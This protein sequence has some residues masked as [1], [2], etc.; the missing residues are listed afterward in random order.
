MKTRS[1]SLVVVGLC[2]FI[3]STSSAML[4]LPS[5]SVTSENKLWN[6]KPV[7]PQP[8]SLSLRYKPT[9]YSPS[10]SPNFSIPKHLSL[11]D[12]ILLALRNNPDV[13]AADL[14]RVTD[15]FALLIEFNKFQPQ[16]TF[17]ATTTYNARGVQ[18]Y[19]V[20]PTVK[21]KNTI[22]TEFDVDYKN[23]LNGSAGGATFTIKQSLLKGF[24]Y[25]NKIPFDNALDQEKVNKLAYKSSVIT[26]VGNVI[27][28][29]RA[30]MNDFASLEIQIHTLKT[31]EETA[32]Q[33]ALKVK[34]GKIAPSELI[35]QEVTVSTTRQQVVTQRESMQQDYRTLLSTLGISP[36]AKL[37][38]DHSVGPVNYKLPDKED[39]IRIALE[40][41]I[42]YQQALLQL[43]VTRR[44][45]ITAKDARKWT[46]NLTASYDADESAPNTPITT[47]GPNATLDFSIPIDDIQSKSDLVQAY[48]NLENAK[49]KLQ[50]QKRDLVNQVLQQ[51]DTIR[52]Q[53]DSVKVDART[54]ELQKQNLAA[55]NL[56]LKYGKSTAFESSQI[57]DQLLQQETTLVSDRI[58]LLNDVTTFNSFLGILL[59]K[60]KIKL[61][62]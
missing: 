50:Q 31:V 29:Y 10:P 46:L 27:T 41:N 47:T 7:L 40:N 19:Q 18:T 13:I 25:V 14:K 24:G 30:L 11:Q 1:Y 62:Y 38:V 12:A 28:Q 26:V 32:K 39:L 52:N 3:V 6:A 9:G 43:K 36:F 55:S 23:N 56:K 33:T 20:N 53:L 37:N 49:L 4:K 2:S 42:A 8:D 17:D 34:L 22:G 35:Q 44:A 60:W 59:D 54:V 16:Y 15:K 57:Q 45:L 21:L 5:P 58:T 48:I 51:I 61:R